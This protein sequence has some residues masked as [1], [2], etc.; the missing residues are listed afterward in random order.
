MSYSFRDLH[1]SKDIAVKTYL[2]PRS[3]AEALE[4]LTEY[5]GRARVIAGGTDVIPQL[6][7]RDYELDALVDVTRLPDLNY[8]DKQGSSVLLGGLVTHAQV[9]SST[10]IKENA[11]LL[12]MGAA[13]VGSP[14]IRNVATVAGN[15]I[16]AQPAADTTIPLLALNATVT[17][18]SHEGE[19]SVSLTDFY[20]GKDSIALDC[21]KEIL[22]RIEFKAVGENSG[23]SYLR[24]SKR[25]AMTLPMLVM[26]AV[27]TVDPQSKVISDAA[28]AFGPVAP[29]PYRAK[30]A[31]DRLR[32]A[33]IEMKSLLE[34][35]DL[36]M[37]ECNPR[38]SC[39]RG[40]CD[41]R[42][43]MANVFVRRG[44]KIAL[45]KAGYPLS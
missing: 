6:R 42:C 38:N 35:A 7:R 36:A 24:L 23:A 34:A 40:S 30:Q 17:I 9:A 21:S 14:Q 10:L 5:H 26:G 15:I 32:G 43:E 27:V 41:Y 16:S 4:M 28:I 8:I 20:F 12:A 29:T 19:R 31:E 33:S 45:E 37:Q 1:W 2:Q 22:T 18:A 11:D 39:L 3:L 25:K 44:V 13:N